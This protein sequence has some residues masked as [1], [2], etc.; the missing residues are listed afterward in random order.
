[1]SVSLKN[2][3]ES[4]FQDNQRRNLNVMIKI[5]KNKILNKSNQIIAR[6]NN[7]NNY[8]SSIKINEISLYEN[9]AIKDD[10]YSH[11]SV[12]P[13]KNR[14]KS[15]SMKNEF[16]NNEISLKGTSNHTKQKKNFFKRKKS[17]EISNIHEK[18]LTFKDL[19][20]Q[21][22]SARNM[23]EERINRANKYYNKLM[24]YVKY[25]AIDEVV[26]FILNFLSREEISLLINYNFEHV[27]FSNSQETCLFE[28]YLQ[29]RSK[30]SNKIIDQED[31]LFKFE[32]ILDKKYSENE[33]SE[34]NFS[35]Y[36]IDAFSNL[37]VQD[38]DLD[39]FLNSIGTSN[40]FIEFSIE[41]LVSRTCNVS[42]EINKTVVDCIK[43]EIIDINT[44]M[45]KGVNRELFN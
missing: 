20:E 37:K 34:E 40:L 39:G 23:G 32:E 38:E 10:K 31:N 42:L 22:E 8:T 3:D 6:R 14:F 33:E 44:G 28:V 11:L 15:F 45:Y 5:I 16:E 25:H 1:M 18:K 4:I 26:E 43:K 2:N 36:F 19:L 35:G 9:S 17:E 7:A 12:V 24:S 30:I 13:V 21:I 27:F 41:Y 29:T